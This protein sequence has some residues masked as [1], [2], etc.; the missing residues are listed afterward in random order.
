[1]RLLLDTHVLL[2]WLAN[3]TLLAEGARRTIEDGKSLVYVSAAVAWEIAI[4]SALGKLRVGNLE[5]AL[6]ENQFLPLP[7][8]VTHA[9]ALQKLPLHH[10][11]P[12]DRMLVAQAMSEGLT[13]VSRDADIQRY[14]IAHLAA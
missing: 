13:L 6:D 5:E 7:I 1:M 14:P 8:T 2:W 11:D 3:P 9:L 10:R 4:K 12:F